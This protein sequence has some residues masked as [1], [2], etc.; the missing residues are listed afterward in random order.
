VVRQ[1]TPEEAL[2]LAQGPLSGEVLRLAASYVQPLF[3]LTGPG[4]GGQ[5]RNGTT[6]FLDAGQGVFGVT[7]GH[8]FDAYIEQ[9]D[10]A[11][12]LCHVGMHGL[13]F[14]LQARLIDRG[15]RVD[16]A[17]YR[18]QP[19]EIGL[20]GATIRCEPNWPPRRPLPARGVFYA[21]YPG[22]ARKLVGK[23]TIEWGLY[24]AGGVSTSVDDESIVCRME[25]DNLVE[26]LGLPIPE[27]GYDVGGVSGAPLFVVGESSLVYWR[28]AGV[29][30]EG[31]GV[32]FEHVRA[33]HADRIRSDGTIDD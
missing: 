14:D 10:G 15:R 29:I 33:T 17:T 1:L 12:G 5:I 24:G 8:V 31:G 2:A 22:A 32:M 18:I 4:A 9:K 16:V 19:S 25:R 11:G 30:H 21:G 28:L 6:F 7:A 20:L 13:R 23:R 27:V 26:A 3:W